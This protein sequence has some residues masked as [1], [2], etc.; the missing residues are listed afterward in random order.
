MPKMEISMCEHLKMGGV[1]FVSP[2][3]Y[4]WLTFG[5]LS[6]PGYVELN[7]KMGLNPGPTKTI[8]WKEAFQINITSLK[9]DYIDL[10]FLKR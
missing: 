10:F 9:I 6:Q 5:Q 4:S 1:E 8:K 3:S 2:E 7:I